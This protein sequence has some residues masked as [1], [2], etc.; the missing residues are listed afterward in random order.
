MQQENLW[1]VPDFYTL[2]MTNQCN[3]QCGHCYWHKEKPWMMSY[4]DVK[5]TLAQISSIQKS[6][7]KDKVKVLFSGG[8]CTLWEDKDY[9]MNFG[10]LLVY[11]HKQGIVPRLFT[12]G[13]NF[14]NMSGIE[15]IFGKFFEQYSD[16]RI[17]VNMSIDTFHQN[18]EGENCQA[19]DNLLEYRDAHLSI[20]IEAAS[21]VSLKPEEMV[22]HAMIEHY[23]TRGVEWKVDAIVSWGKCVELQEYVPKIKIQGCDKSNLGIFSRLFYEKLLNHNIVSNWQD[24]EQIPNREIIQKLN[25]CGR[26]PSATIL[27]ND[28]YY[29]CIPHS[30]ARHDAFVV[31]SKGELSTERALEF[32]RRMP[33]LREIRK[34]GMVEVADQLKNQLTPGSGKRIEQIINESS[35]SPK[36]LNCS[37]C[38]KLFEEGI[39]QE[40]N[41]SLKN[42]S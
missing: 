17:K 6:A 2:G 12:N 42:T 21:I 10:S 38:L 33:L 7:S 22:P 24:Y 34:H 27:W 9:N 5:T 30:I 16:G 40:L 18:F 25:F 20:D 13:K 37:M 36:Y 32:Q 15:K 3:S 39:W 4:Q 35:D 8:E 28:R 26:T 19:L 11:E 29:H 23:Q 14:R 1:S 31:A 41:A